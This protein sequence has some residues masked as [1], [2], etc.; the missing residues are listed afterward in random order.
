ML[1]SLFPDLYPVRK[2]L[3]DHRELLK[4]NGF[5][6]AVRMDVSVSQ[7]L[8]PQRSAPHLWRG[9]ILEAKRDYIAAAHA[10]NQSKAHAALYDWQSSFRL[11]KLLS[12]QLGDLSAANIERDH[13][14]TI[15]GPAQFAWYN[16]DTSGQV[17]TF[18]A[19]AVARDGAG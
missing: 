9:M 15:W 11:W 18:Q 13:L 19:T 3:I 17:V 16:S 7:H 14:L 1:R 8:Y 12:K 5:S 2:L 10:Y 6:E 4:P